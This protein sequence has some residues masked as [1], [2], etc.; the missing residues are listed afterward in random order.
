MKAYGL[1]Q[2][3]NFWFCNLKIL[4]TIL[5]EDEFSWHPF[6]LTNYSHP[7]PPGSVST[8]QIKR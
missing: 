5:A 1:G 4:R 6:S 7:P 3:Q 2:D 8:Q